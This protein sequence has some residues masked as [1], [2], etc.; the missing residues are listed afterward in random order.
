MSNG[1]PFHKKMPAAAEAAAEV[2][3]QRYTSSQIEDMRRDM[4]AL[5]PAVA[6]VDE[7]V[8][9][10]NPELGRTGVVCPFVPEAT[11]QDLLQ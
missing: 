6:W 10:T 7:F 5:A 3:A 1:C 4:E 11:R 2:K 8:K 9:Q